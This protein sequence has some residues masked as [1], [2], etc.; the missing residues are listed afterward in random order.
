VFDTSAATASWDFADDPTHRRTSAIA[1]V[2]RQSQRSHQDTSK[3]PDLS[4]ERGV[5]AKAMD[6]AR[7]VAS[8]SDWLARYVASVAIGLPVGVGDNSPRQGIRP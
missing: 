5:R 1:D 4:L 6:R 3:Q 7:N 8:E 2:T